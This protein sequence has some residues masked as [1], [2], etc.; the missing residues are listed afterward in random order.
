MAKKTPQQ[1]MG[2]A[3]TKKQIKAYMK[4][5]SKCPRCRSSSYEGG[6]VE[7]EDG[8]AVQNC[9]CI[10]CGLMWTDTYMLKSF[11]YWDDTEHG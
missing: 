8:G 2:T 5:S 6:S 1:L 9:S 11:T 4:D 7:I 10:E 3:L